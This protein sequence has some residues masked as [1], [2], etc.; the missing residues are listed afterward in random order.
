MPTYNIQGWI[1][2]GTGIANTLI[3][4][5][6]DDDDAVMS[7]YFTD[8]F[9]ET[10]TIAGTTYTN[11]QGG[12]YRLTFTDSGGT[13][14]TEDF[15]LWSTGSNFVFAPLPGSNFDSGSVINTLVGWQNWTTG[16]NWV[17]VTC[18][19]AGTLIETA[20][21]PRPI[22]TI[23][24]GDQV[25]TCDGPSTVMWAGRRTVS[26]EEL[27]TSPNLKPIRIMAGALGN[28]LPKR[29]LVVS[30][31]HRMLVQSKAAKSM[32]GT[33]AVL[34]PAIKLTA[35]PG[36]FVDDG[37]SEVEYFHLLFDCHKVIFAEATPTESLFTG[38]E[39]L[40]SVSQAARKEI[41]KLFPEIAD[42]NYKP[43]PAR[44]IPAGRVQKM[45]VA[46]HLKN[47]NPLSPRLL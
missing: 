3:P 6:I 12:T 32:C 30:R 33:D 1:W 40:K 17:D 25:L 45:L 42:L 16:F 47:K 43:K 11:P 8:D 18:F 9:T 39:A 28:G 26:Q 15:L 38:P 13:T 41:L 20:R 10:I 23:K 36:I 27:T 46:Q 31:Q 5:T 29:D 2:A 37:F 14:Y 7:P 24:T 44:H 21:G 19:T 35:L 4:L 34:I 22:E